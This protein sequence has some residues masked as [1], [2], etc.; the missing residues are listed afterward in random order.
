MKIRNAVVGDAPVPRRAMI[1]RAEALTIDM[2]VGSLALVPVVLNA[3]PIDRDCSKQEFQAAFVPL[4]FHGDWLRSVDQCGQSGSIYENLTI[5]APHILLLP[6]ASVEQDTDRRHVKLRP[7]P[8]DHGATELAIQLKDNVFVASTQDGASIAAVSWSLRE[9][10]TARK[11]DNIRL[12]LANAA[13][14]TKKF[15][16]F[17]SAFV[18]PEVLKR[19]YLAQETLVMRLGAVGRVRR[20][21]LAAAAFGQ[22]QDQFGGRGETFIFVRK[23]VADHYMKSALSRK[24]FDHRPSVK[25]PDKTKVHIKWRPTP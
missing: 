1:R 14:P 18:C 15:N 20:A 16:R 21:V 10:D 2:L 13:C 7:R 23:K 25:W 17:H 19:R 9:P 11:M 6:V 8:A 4:R 12:G 24:L 3:A 5:G 22:P